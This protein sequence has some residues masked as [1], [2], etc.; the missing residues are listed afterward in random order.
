MLAG[1]Y[2]RNKWDRRGLHVSG[3]SMTTGHSSIGVM[4]K[5]VSEDCNLACDH[6]DYSSKVS[7][8]QVMSNVSFLPI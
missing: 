4:W 6:L 3:G 2:L 5:T 8:A 7:S 1:C